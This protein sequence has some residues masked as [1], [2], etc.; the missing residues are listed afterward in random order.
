MTVYLYAMPA[1]FPGNVTRRAESTLEPVLLATETPHGAPLTLDTEGKA[2][3]TTEADEVS[4]WLV[5]PYPTTG[6]G[7]DGNSAPAG[8]IQDRLLRGYISVRLSAAETQTAVK[9][10]PVCLI[11]EAGNGFAVGDL[12]VSAGDPIPG[13]VFMGPQDSDGNAEIAF[14]L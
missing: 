13:A 7:S 3:P 12:A 8:T 11:A 14:N 6:V 10:A 2:V 1:G 4:A 9:G 5:R